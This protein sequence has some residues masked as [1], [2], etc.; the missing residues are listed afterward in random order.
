MH[1]LSWCRPRSLVLIPSME[2]VPSGSAN[3][4]NKATMELLPEPVR[5]TIP[6]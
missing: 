1:P 4:Y 2:I 6:I 3:R 5:P